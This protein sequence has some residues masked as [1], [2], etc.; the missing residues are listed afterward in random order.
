MKR[1][2][3]SI[4][5]PEQAVKAFLKQIRDDRVNLHGFAM[6]LSDEMIYEGYFEPF[7]AD[8]MHRMYSVGKSFTS[9]AIGLLEE[10]GKLSL[11]DFICTYF[12]D[13]LPEEGV[14]PLI[15]RM[16][17]R[18]MLCMTTAH[19][20]TTYKRYDGDDWVKSFFC[21]E[22]SH[23]SGTIFSYDTSSTHVLSAL[24]ER[25]SGME[26]I[27][28][29]RV[30]FLNQIGF[31]KEAKFLKDP[32]GVSQGGSG[33]ICTLRDLTK[34]ANLCVHMGE[35]QGEQLL[36]RD[37]LMEATKKQVD[38]VLQPY[39]DEQFGYGYQIWKTRYDGFCF[40]GMGGQLAVCF[41]KYH[42]VFTTM[43]DT[44]G[45][46]DGLK[47]IYDAFYQHIY[48][49]LEKDVK[50]KD[51]DEK[52]EE[53][54]SILE[55]LKIKPLSALYEASMEVVHAQGRYRFTTNPMGLEEFNITFLED[56]GV[57]DYQ[58]NG[59]A[60]RL[61]FHLKEFAY[62][63]FPGTS[64]TCMSSAV[65]LAKDVLFIKTNVIEECFASLSMVLVFREETVTICMKRVAEM[66]LQDYEGFATGIRI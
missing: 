65:W 58:K 2:D 24:V 49:C 31:S 11:E 33:L 5:I 59:K 19:H 13:K 62:Q 27:E 14:H 52:E 66:F 8:S 57:L 42:F 6:M 12:N 38:T 37:Y 32:M 10:E 64:Y 21:V 26:L 34:V 25:L 20:S 17:I 44:Q 35:Y 39:L 23:K 54:F 47:N 3:S 48:P 29:L 56:V 22:P 46:P 61:K 51:I 15:E 4:V 45:S 16:T 18:D 60:H 40:Y 41:P 30:K 36:P 63:N 9:L 53:L 55:K 28:Y 50:E 1:K 7:H 43:G